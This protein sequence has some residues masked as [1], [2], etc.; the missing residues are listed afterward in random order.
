M[1]LCPALSDRSDLF[2]QG[3]KSTC[4]GVALAFLFNEFLCL[5]L[6]FHKLFLLLFELPDLIL[7]FFLFLQ[8]FILH[9][10]VVSEEQHFSVNQGL[11]GVSFKTHVN[12]KNNVVE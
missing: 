2:F 9:F 8:E 11:E 6:P 10:I 7:E 1:D 3:R 4:I 5:F 12:Q